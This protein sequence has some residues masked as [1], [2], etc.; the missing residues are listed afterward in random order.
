M[1]R[2]LLNRTPHRKAEKGEPVTDQLLAADCEFCVDV[3]I[4]AITDN[5]LQCG[6]CSH[7]RVLDVR[8]TGRVLL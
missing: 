4:H 6:K 7:V 8:E 5:G 3:T 1:G 2:P